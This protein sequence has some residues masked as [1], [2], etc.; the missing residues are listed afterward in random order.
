MMGRERCSGTVAVE[1]ALV[2][3]IVIF[4]L[5]AVAEVGLLLNAQLVLN[6]AA[7]EG[8]RRAAVEGGA[9]SDVY[10]RIEACLELGAISPDAV[11]IYISPYTATYGHTIRLRLSHDY[12]FKT[13][14][15]RGMIG[16]CVPLRAEVLTRSEKVPQS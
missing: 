7:R 10:S 6:H 12:R 16:T 15:L 3:T 4:L 2:G 11:D 9:T 8:A 1:F 14:L 13:P 5:F